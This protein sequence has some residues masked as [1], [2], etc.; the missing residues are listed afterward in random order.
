MFKKYLHLEKFGNDEVDSIQFGECYIFPKLDGTNGSVWFD[1][2]IHAGSRT[3]ELSLESDNA[4]FYAAMK[5]DERLQKFFKHHPMIT[6]YGEWLCSHILK[7]YQ[8]DAWRKFYIFDVYNR[9]NESFIPYPDYQPHMESF[10]LDYIPCQSVIR[11]PTEDQL[12]VELENN[13]FLIKEGCGYGEGIV[14]KNYAYKNRFGRYCC[15]K[16]VSNQFKEKHRKA[17]GP[18]VK[19]LSKMIEQEIIDNYVDSHLVEK[20]YAKIK[21]ESG[22]NSKMI[23]RLLSTVFHDLI[24]EEIW[25]IVKKMKN[26][27]IDFKALNQ[28]CII[29]IKELKPE[30]F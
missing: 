4:G 10:G 5:D 16:I 28:L 27:T 9:D 22:W 8:D 6:L 3:R 26:P 20:V 23:P 19:N 29:K 13:K 25:D 12:L 2:G 1:D 18:T 7:T 24:T 30:L 15:A 17:M 14:I 11:N 21:N